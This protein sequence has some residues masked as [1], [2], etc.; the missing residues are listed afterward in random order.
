MCDSRTVGWKRCV[1][2]TAVVVYSGYT[3]HSSDP[4]RTHPLVNVKPARAARENV[5]PL[6]C[7]PSSCQTK[8]IP[9]SSGV[10]FV[11]TCANINLVSGSR[12][13][14][15]CSAGECRW[16]FCWFKFVCNGLLGVWSFSQELFWKG[17]RIVSSIALHCFIK[18]KYIFGEKILKNEKSCTPLKL[19][20]SLISLN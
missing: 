17:C 15:Q 16:E 19:A 9:Y 1:F 2:Q 11:I 5:W 12:R 3:R 6:Y 8:N 13:D 20:W 7:H 4:W 18:F 10:F 14:V